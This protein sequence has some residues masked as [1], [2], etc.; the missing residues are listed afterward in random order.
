M[1]IIRPTK[2]TVRRSEVRISIELPLLINS[3]FYTF[4]YCTKDVSILIRVLHKDNE[5]I[6]GSKDESGVTPVLR[7]YSIA[8]AALSRTG[9]ISDDILVADFMQALL[10]Q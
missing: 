9:K 2:V 10:E 8:T 4:Y 6:V 7:K 3:E 5:S 1:G